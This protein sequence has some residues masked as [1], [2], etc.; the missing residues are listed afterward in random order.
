[1]KKIIRAMMITSIV[2]VF[3]G[4]TND[5]SK[6][7]DV[8][9]SDKQDEVKINEN[10]DMTEDG[11]EDSFSEDVEEI[12]MFEDEVFE[13]VVLRSLGIENR[14]LY[15]SDLEGIKCIRLFSE[16]AYGEMFSY[17]SYEYG[18]DVSEFEWQQFSMPT[19]QDDSVWYHDKTIAT[20]HDIRYFKELE[21]LEINT[22]EYLLDYIFDKFHNLEPI[23]ELTNLEYFEFRKTPFTDFA[24]LNNCKQLHYIGVENTKIENLDFLLGLTELREYTHL[25][26]DEWDEDEILHDIS[27][28]SECIKITE[29]N[30]SMN[31]IVDISALSNLTDLRSLNL[32]ENGIKDL[33]ALAGMDELEFLDLSDNIIEDI[34]AVSEMSELYELNLSWN[35]IMNYRPLVGA[36]KLTV[37]DLSYNDLEQFD[38]ENG[39]MNLESLS[40]AD[41]DNFEFE[42]ISHLRN[43]KVLD[44]TDT[45]LIDIS[46]M[47]QM[48]NLEELDLSVNE[49]SDFTFLHDMI[50]L[51]DLNVSFNPVEILPDFS[52][53]HNLEYLVIAEEYLHLLNGIDEDRT[54]LYSY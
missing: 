52:E 19:H 4:C 2:M 32:E 50:T 1:M 40:V 14:K 28:I 16:Y 42:E 37:L 6:F 48:I 17:D 45:G 23:G 27:G 38:L 26:S 18:D 11:G 41:C 39:L 49:I 8:E 34:S 7:I 36:T 53:H 22:G 44:L 3:F 43:L 46:Q 29:L 35:K 10:R 15:P 33:S 51:R 5:E 31:S 24:P 9:S 25:S 54:H 21:Y 13:A 47:S 20:F 12:L 30:L